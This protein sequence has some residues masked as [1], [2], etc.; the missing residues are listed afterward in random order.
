MTLC[1]WQH[2][3]AALYNMILTDSEDALSEEHCA[4]RSKHCTG[5]EGSA[6]LGRDL[7]QVGIG[8]RLDSNLPALSRARVW[9]HSFTMAEHIQQEAIAREGP[10]HNEEFFH[11]LKTVIQGET[12]SHAMQFAQRLRDTADE[13]LVTPLENFVAA[14]HRELGLAEELDRADEAAETE[15]EKE[16]P[17]PALQRQMLRAPSTHQ[18]ENLVVP[19]EMVVAD[20]ELSDGRNVILN[21]QSAKHDRCRELGRQ[22]LYRNVT[23]SIKFVASTRWKF[24]IR[25]I[26]KTQSEYRTSYVMG[27]VTTREHGRQDMTA[28][29]IFST[30]RQFWL[31]HY[32]AM[33]VLIMDQ[34]TEFGADF[35]HLCQSRDILPVVTDLGTPWQNSVVERH[36]ALFKNGIR[37]SVQAGSSDDGGR[38]Q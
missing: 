23:A 24:G 26:E 27:H 3:R 36:G 34:G 14:A 20:G 21:V 15:V 11:L 22:Q 18:L 9:T 35:Q 38:S 5:I 1:T 32:D 19:C 10:L 31:E 25:W 6:W 8:A 16:T 4:R 28:T 29:E 13:E 17:S 12:P 37:E 30:L 7:R 2:E 33:E